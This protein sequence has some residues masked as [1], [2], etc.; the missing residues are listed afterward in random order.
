MQVWWRT[1]SQRRADSLADEAK[2]LAAEGQ[3]ARAEA[4]L[5]QVVRLHTD[6]PALSLG[7]ARSLNG[8]GR[9]TE[10]LRVLA[11]AKADDP[12][13]GEGALA[14]LF[15]ALTAQALLGLDRPDEAEPRARH[16]VDLARGHYHPNNH[17]AL[18]AAT[19]LCRALAA[20]DR[21]HEAEEQLTRCATA[22]R[23]HFGAR[24]P[25]TVAVETELA[26]LARS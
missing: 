12:Q 24:H 4:V 15:V 8:L 10:A 19:T 14:V 26:A 6:R 1:R 9:A 16:A 7:L 13:V 11:E 22:W 18:E 5:R 17:R 23:E 3:W 2:R 20:Q 21:R 25:H